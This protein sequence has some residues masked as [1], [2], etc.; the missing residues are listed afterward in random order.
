MADFRK[1][2][3]SQPELARYEQFLAAVEPSE[4]PTP[5][6]TAFSAQVQ[7]RYRHLLE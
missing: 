5:E 2:V 3:A 4:P 7:A 1:L 6:M